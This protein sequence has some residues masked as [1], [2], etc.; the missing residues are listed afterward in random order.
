MTRILIIEDE[1]GLVTVLM[2]RLL[3]EGY[4]VQAAERGDDGERMART[5][6]FDLLILDLMLPGRSGLDVC[7]NLRAADLETPILMLT[8]RGELVDKVVGLR[9]G[10]DDYLTKPFAMAELLARIEAL[11]RRAESS[12]PAR[13]FGFGDVTIDE[14]RGEVKRGGELVEL[15]SKEFDLLL[16]LIRNPEVILSRDRLL[17]EV[18]NYDAPI[19]SRTIDVHISGLRQK[20]EPNVRRPRYIRTVHGLGYK[21]IP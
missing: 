12:P 1:A 17:R 18:W 16:Y 10:A 20:F 6:R 7:R 14:E 15:S 5:G 2:D 11:L 8:A 9:M 19:P 13:T 3:A 21:F 4:E